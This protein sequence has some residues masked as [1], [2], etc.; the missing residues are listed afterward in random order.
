MN[1]NESFGPDQHVAGP[2]GKL[3]HPM[4]RTMQ[5]VGAG[6]GAGAAVGAMTRGQN[7]VLIGVLVGSA[8]GLIIDQILRHREKQKENTYFAGVESESCNCAPQPLIN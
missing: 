7:G 3:H 2:D 1:L 4:T 5:A 6:A 8:G